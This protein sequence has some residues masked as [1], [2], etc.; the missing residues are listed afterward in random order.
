MRNASAHVFPSLAGRSGGE[1]GEDLQHLRLQDAHER[2]ASR[3]QLHPAGAAGRAAHGTHAAP[4]LLLPFR[5]QSSSAGWSKR[6][7]CAIMDAPLTCALIVTSGRNPHLRALVSDFNTSRAD[8]A[9]CWFASYSQILSKVVF[10]TGKQHNNYESKAVPS[11]H[12]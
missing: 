7:Y 8:S 12:H 5:Q 10:M 3:E 2:R 11:S 9:T 6:R 1:G 4:L